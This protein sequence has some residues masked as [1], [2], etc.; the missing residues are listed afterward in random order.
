MA[1]VRVKIRKA[2]GPK[3]RFEKRMVSAGEG[4]VS[5]WIGGASCSE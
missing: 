1:K 5:G 2:L 3:A 4:V